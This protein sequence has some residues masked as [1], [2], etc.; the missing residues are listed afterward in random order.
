M[1]QASISCDSG[2][3]SCKMPGT[4][5]I[6]GALETLLWP[7]AKR[8]VMEQLVPY[9]PWLLVSEHPRAVE[10]AHS[11]GIRLVIFYCAFRKKAHL[12][13]CCI[14]VVGC[15]VQ[16]SKL[17]KRESLH[18]A[19]QQGSNC[20]LPELKKKIL[21]EWISQDLIPHTGQCSEENLIKENI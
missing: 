1:V 20:R 7:P 2:S 11:Q 3:S 10:T 5:H 8:I 9:A 18:L 4:L 13:L 21:L 19:K 14:W 12:R 17:C 16:A 6:Q 15:K